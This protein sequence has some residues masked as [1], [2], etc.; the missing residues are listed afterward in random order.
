MTLGTVIM[1]LSDKKNNAPIPY[2]DSKLTRLLQ[3]ALE[4]DSKV[5][6]ICNISPSS[7]AYDETLSTLKF[8]QRAK[9]IKQTIVKNDVTDSK[10]LI[11]KYQNEIHLLQDRLREMEIRMSQEE[12]KAVSAEVT[13]RLSML[14]EEKEVSDAKIESILQEKLQLQQDLDRLKSFIINADGLKPA[15]PSYEIEEKNKHDG[16]LKTPFKRFSTV[17]SRSGSGN[18]DLTPAK[19]EELKYEDRFEKQE[20]MLTAG[21]ENVISEL[22]SDEPLKNISVLGPTPSLDECLRIIEE[23]AKTIEELKKSVKENRNLAEIIR[24]QDDII[25]KMEEEIEAK[26]DEIELIG[27]ELKLCRNN[28]SKMQIAMKIKNFKK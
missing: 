18:F 14:Q 4:G 12:N 21:I 15:R 23:Q 13:E 22:Y 1:R 19:V 16:Y 26:T 9:K 5:S 17:A 24:E 27:D 11:V 28:L 8:A 10:A 6:I 2:R 3:P 20:T 25:H 7:N